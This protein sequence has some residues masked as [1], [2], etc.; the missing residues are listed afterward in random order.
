LTYRLGRAFLLTTTWFAISTQ[1]DILIS[2]I[3]DRDINMVCL[4][5]DLARLENFFL[6]RDKTRDENS[7]AC[8]TN[9]K[10]EN[11]EYFTPIDIKQTNYVFEYIN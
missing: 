3:Y 8:F 1:L 5:K 6:Y 9:T 4:K 7:C 11:S 10:G 2:T